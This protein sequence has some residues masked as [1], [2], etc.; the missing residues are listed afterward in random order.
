MEYS[1]FYAEKACTS[2]PKMYTSTYIFQTYVKV[3]GL[4]LNRSRRIYINLVNWKYNSL[5]V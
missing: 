3:S 4:Y 1:Q 2:R 5:E